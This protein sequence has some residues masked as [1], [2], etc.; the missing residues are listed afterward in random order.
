MPSWTPPNPY[1][2]LG[3]C[4]RKALSQG[5][6]PYISEG[7]PAFARPPSH[8]LSLEGVAVITPRTLSWALPHAHQLHPPGKIRYY[9]R[10]GNSSWLVPMWMES[11]AERLSSCSDLKQFIPLKNTAHC[12]G[13]P[14][15]LRVVPEEHFSNLKHARSGT[16]LHTFTYRV[17]PISISGLISFTVEFT[18]PNP[19]TPS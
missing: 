13:F 9:Q 2:V 16:M 5:G 11:S 4:Y 12:K 15:T 10:R 17:K 19:Q 7:L 8:H 14:N 3:R 18:F 1:L 6:L